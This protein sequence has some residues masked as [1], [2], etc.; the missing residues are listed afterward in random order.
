MQAVTISSHFRCIGMTKSSIGKLFSL[1]RNVD[2]ILCTELVI[3]L[4]RYI[5]SNTQVI[6]MVRWF[7]YIG[8][9]MQ[10]KN[11]TLWIS[12]P[13]QYQNTVPSKLMKNMQQ[14]NSAVT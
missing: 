5:T 14:L 2:V 4:C 1:R 13:M 9:V 7:L 10:V 6:V 3:G 11:M 12:R 8:A